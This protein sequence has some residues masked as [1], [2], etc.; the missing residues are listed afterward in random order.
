MNI[1]QYGSTDLTLLTAHFSIS[2]LHN[3]TKIQYLLYSNCSKCPPPVAK[4]FSPGGRPVP[5]V[6]PFDHGKDISLL[7]VKFATPAYVLCLCERPFYE[8]TDVDFYEPSQ[9]CSLSS[10]VC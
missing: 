3:S 9:E 8:W 1:Q 5:D 10:L 7:H 4:Q 2:L 6:V